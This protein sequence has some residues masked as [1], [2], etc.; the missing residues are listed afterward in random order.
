MNDSMKVVAMAKDPKEIAAIQKGLFLSSIDV[1][2]R[3]ALRLPSA[4]RQTTLAKHT[5]MHP[6]L[7][8]CVDTSTTFD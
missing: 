2:S 1:P 6:L 3:D 7:L 4:K 5:N 8:Q